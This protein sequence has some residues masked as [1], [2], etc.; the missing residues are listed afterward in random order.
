MKFKLNY[1]F[2]LTTLICLL[3]FCFGCSGSK[4][5]VQILVA[6]S[7]YSPFQEINENFDNS[8]IIDYGGSNSL[9]SKV[10]LGSKAEL[11]VL[12]GE[13]PINK[14]ENWSKDNFFYKKEL[15]TNYIVVV[16]N[17]NFKFESINDICG[18]QYS[19]GIA[20]PQIAP[21]G[22]YSIEILNKF[23][24][25]QIMTS[26]NKIKISSDA[27]SLRAALSY[28][29]LDFAFI[30]K[31][32]IKIAK[33]NDYK[34]IFEDE[35]IPIGKITYPIVVLSENES[36]ILNDFFDY[37]DSKEARKIFIRHGFNYID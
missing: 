35:N 31:S 17:K 34:V 7:L 11:L 25:C 16:S 26:K 15:L 19:I 23:P 20:D 14:L 3:F 8:F 24:K 36:E 37:I 1:N 4:D 18:G 21:L 5:K 28:G 32:D 27:M 12:A 33:K 13:E 30:Y 10:I 2:L 22:K 6:A 29:H 9:V